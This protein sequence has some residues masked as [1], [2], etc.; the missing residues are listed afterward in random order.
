MNILFVADII[1]RPGRKALKELLSNIKEEYFIDFCIANGENAAGGF[2]LV[3]KTMDELFKLGIDILTSGNHIWDKKD[4]MPT[5]ALENKVLRP[6]NYP[7]GVPGRGYQI[8]EVKSGV[9]IGIVNLQ[10]RVF[11]VPIDCPFRVADRIISE[12]KGKT[13]III[14]DFHAEATAEKMALGWYLD[15]KVSAVLGTHTHVQTADEK[16]L[17]KGTAYITDVGMTGGMDS[18]IGTKKEPV[19]EKFLLQIPRRFEPSNENLGLN[20]VVVS[21]DEATG[22]ATNI[23]RIQRF[24]N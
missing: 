16:I 24:F 17:P 5:L 2:G 18:V 12:I 14:V 22:K 7:T 9:N 3:K 1:G 10:G 11:M 6:A 8:Y 15:G 21:I 4:F 23:K 20:A 19:L 13:K